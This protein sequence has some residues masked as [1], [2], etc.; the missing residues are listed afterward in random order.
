M[1]GITKAIEQLN[2]KIQLIDFFLYI[3]QKMNE[4]IDD[5]IFL[6]ILE[7]NTFLLFALY[8]EYF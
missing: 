6:T 2:F 3:N 1:N 4:Y 8:R 7:A 5:K